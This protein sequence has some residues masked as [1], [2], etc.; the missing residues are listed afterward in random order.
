MKKVQ[1]IIGS[2][3]P[4][5]MGNQIADWLI[6][7]LARHKALSGIEI[8]VVDLK[9]WHLPLD[10]EPHKPAEQRYTRHHTQAWSTEIARGDGYI[11]LTPQY[12]WG[13]PASLKNALDHLYKEWHHKPAVIVSY[14]HRGGV[15]AAAQLRQVLEGLHMKA[16]ETMPALVFQHEM[17]GP[18]LRM[19]DIG[20]DFAQYEDAVVKAA[21]ELAAAL[22]AGGE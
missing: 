2:V 19:A 11:F 4:V 10:D 17:L 22:A 7:V 13:Y 5:R 6:A 9:E 21:N 15:R 20:K 18:D 12:N 14:G 1:L 8:E 16:V 3:R